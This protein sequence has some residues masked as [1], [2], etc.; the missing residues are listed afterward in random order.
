MR[1][2]RIS[3]FPKFPAGF[4][5]REFVNADILEVMEKKCNISAAPKPTY[6]E[7]CDFAMQLATEHR[8]DRELLFLIHYPVAA[9]PPPE[10]W[11][12]FMGWAAR[13][14]AKAAA[15]LTG[16]L[17]E[18]Y[19]R[20]LRY[21]R[22]RPKP[23]RVWAWTRRPL[24]YAHPPSRR[25]GHLPLWLHPDVSYRRREPVSRPRW[26]RHDTAAPPGLPD[27]R[28]GGG[29]PYTGD[30]RLPRKR[31]LRFEMPFDNRMMIQHSA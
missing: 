5:H 23:R 11:S 10:P 8:V 28:P 31:Q 29:D 6:R 9:S 13:I 22:R 16:R 27:T 20:R 7:V 3:H 24:V 1:I 21:L 12:F 26:L 18:E 15:V 14:R 2:L 19:R 30:L 4:S 17:A 25:R